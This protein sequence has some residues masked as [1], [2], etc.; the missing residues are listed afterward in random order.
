MADLLINGKDAFEKY[1]VRMGDGFL[2]ALWELAPLKEYITND[3]SLE[4]GVQY[5]KK[6]PKIN[7]RT[8]TLV[9]TI[10]GNTKEDFLTKKRNFQTILYSGNVK[11]SVPSDSDCTYQLKYK[12]GVSYAQNIQRTFCKIAAKFTESVPTQTARHI[13]DE[14]DSVEIV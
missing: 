12:S 8:L 5:D 9:F 10:E 13:M 2:D 4:D 7:E 1:G 14:D 11:I 3:N 6:I